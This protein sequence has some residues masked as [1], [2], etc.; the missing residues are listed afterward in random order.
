MKSRPV[1]LNILTIRMPITAYVSILHRL[2]G[3]LTFL[4]VPCLLYALQRSLH[5]PESYAALLDCLATPW[6]TAVT[7]FMTMGLVYHLLAGIKH[8]LMDLHIGETV[9]ASKAFSWLVLIGF[10]AIAGAS[11]W[12]IWGY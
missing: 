1:N 6:V 7:W 9:C 4:F 11:A 5:S 3:L 2:S 10:A 8:L 12:Q